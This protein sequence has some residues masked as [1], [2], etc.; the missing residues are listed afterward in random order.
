MAEE[1][2]QAQLLANSEQ[3]RLNN[4]GLRD[5]DEPQQE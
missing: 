3:R 2:K 5:G 1:S 4:Q